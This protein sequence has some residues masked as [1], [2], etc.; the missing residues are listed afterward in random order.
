[1]TSEELE[2]TVLKL[3]YQVSIIGQTIDHDRHPIEALV[4]GMNW[5][6]AE[7]DRVH[8]V[9]ERWDER[10]EEH[11]PLERFEF[12]QDFA[13]AVGVNYQGLK[14]IVLAFYRNGQWTNVCEAYV[15]TFGDTPALEYHS[16]MRRER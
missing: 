16:I 15:D 1:M 13:D 8:D 12:E 3:Q 5:G 2:R 6:S 7:L 14:S 11:R 4:L 9:F 10:L